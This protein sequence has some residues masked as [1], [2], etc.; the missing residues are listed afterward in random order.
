L[1][2]QRDAEVVLALWREV[3][4]QL[5][6]LAEDAPETEGLR[7]EAARLRD[8]YQRIVTRAIAPAPE[9]VDALQAEPT[10]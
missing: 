8:E 4:R 3:E 10:G 6:P 7:A 9:A 5:S 2:H 1:T